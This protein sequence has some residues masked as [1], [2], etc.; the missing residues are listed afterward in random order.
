M[1]TEDL[2][3]RERTET[4]PL[5]WP[6]DD[7]SPHIEQNKRYSVNVIEAK[8][9]FIKVQESI[10]WHVT[11]DQWQSLAQELVK[12]SMVFV[13]KHG[14]PIAVACGLSRDNNWVELAWVAVT[15]AHRGLG[16][17]KM[18]CAVA[19]DQ[20]LKL[21]DSKIYG[22]TQD[23]RLDALKIY[24]ELGFHP[25]YRVDK[26]TRWMSICDKLRKP[27]TPTIWGWPLNV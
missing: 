26:V 12:G 2:P 5:I 21:G 19:V 18:V 11:D 16:I 25:F 8:A 4:V 1:H 27:F 9:D 20:L 14:E 3:V 6:Q 10:G 23:E 13:S 22:S 24:L 7:Q 15:P 17:G